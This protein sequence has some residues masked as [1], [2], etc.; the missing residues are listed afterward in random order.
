MLLVGVSLQVYYT[1]HKFYTVTDLSYNNSKLSVNVNDTMA[2]LT[3]LYLG[4]TY[5]IYVTTISQGS[6][7]DR[8]DLLN[9]RTTS[10]G[11]KK[12]VPIILCVLHNVVL[13]QIF[14]S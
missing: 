9:F 8:S 1:P 2:T 4:T 10:T 11:K 14:R 13:K 6:E 12:V 5:S 7:G 3:H